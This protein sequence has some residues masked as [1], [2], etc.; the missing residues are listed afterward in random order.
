[1]DGMGRT[2]TTQGKERRERNHSASYRMRREGRW[3][4]AEVVN[5]T[6]TN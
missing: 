3:K 6:E 2:I 5:E 4:M 1:M